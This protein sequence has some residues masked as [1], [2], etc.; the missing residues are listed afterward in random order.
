[1]RGLTLLVRLGPVDL[2]NIRRDP[3]LFWVPVFPLLLAL[4]IRWGVPPLAATVAAST[5]FD[6]AAW[7]PL[8][9]SCFVV[10]MPGLIGT[11]TG[12]LLLDE[13]DDGVLSAILVTPVSSGAY[14]GYRVA[15][16]LAVGFVATMLTYPL[17]GLTP[18]PVADL[19]AAALLGSF[20]APF[21][22]LYLAS[23]AEN[24]VTGFA[25]MKLMNAVQILPVVGYFMPMPAQLLIGVLPSYWPM[26]V[27]W[28]AA[29]G[30]PY[31]AYVAAGL[32]VNAIAVAA[33]MK[34]F[35]RVVHRCR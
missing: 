19:A 6:L 16:P 32:V 8:L 2:K 5:G 25:M 31:G 18:L 33:L 29:A 13:R 4:V 1:M 21:M 9:M 14:V 3:L 34:R 22:A 23:F 35:D 10:M 27:V 17:A 15:T 20:G 11:V 30:R 28:L 24:K 12:F 26:K 7:Y